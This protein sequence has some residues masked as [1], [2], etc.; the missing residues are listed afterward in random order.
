MFYT[1]SLFFKLQI[2]KTKWNKC[3]KPST[4]GLN[5]KN[6]TVAGV[7]QSSNTTLYSTMALTSFDLS[8]IFSYHSTSLGLLIASVE[9]ED[10]GIYS[11]HL[12]LEGMTKYAPMKPENKNDM[13]WQKYKRIA[14][15][16]HVANINLITS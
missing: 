11:H 8:N 10:S 14:A 9:V 5:K 16:K 2:T 7:K 4:L 3:W 12:H 6:R 1:G 15:I 13:K